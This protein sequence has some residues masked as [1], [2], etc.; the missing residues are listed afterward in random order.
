MF[1]FISEVSHLDWGR[2]DGHCSDVFQ[3]LVSRFASL[4]LTLEMW[5][6]L[7]GHLD[8][9]EEVDF[10]R[11][12]VKF[13][14]VQGDGILDPVHSHSQMSFDWTFLLHYKPTSANQITQVVW[15]QGIGVGRLRAVSS[16]TGRNV[17]SFLFFKENIHVVS[18]WIYYWRQEKKIPPTEV[19]E[20]LVY[21]T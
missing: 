16:E 6:H 8:T 21:K 12:N 4:V 10:H 9:H 11:L 2:L 5:W 13:E 14:T 18:W 20:M 19:S 17:V 15:I 3:H 1:C 7:W